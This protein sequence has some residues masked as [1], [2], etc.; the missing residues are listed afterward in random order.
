MNE[1]FTALR[2]SLETKTEEQEKQLREEAETRAVMVSEV[3]RLKERLTEL[4]TADKE[5]KEV[6]SHH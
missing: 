6:R 2:Q 4:E 3:N 5:L 1:T